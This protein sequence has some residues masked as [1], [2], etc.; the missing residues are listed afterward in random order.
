MLSRWVYIENWADTPL[1]TDTWRCGCTCVCVFFFVCVHVLHMHVYCVTAWGEHLFADHKVNYKHSRSVTPKKRKYLYTKS[2]YR[3]S[4][5]NMYVCPVLKSF[6]HHIRQAQSNRIISLM[7]YPHYPASNHVTQSCN[8]THL[9]YRESSLTNNNTRSV[10]HGAW[11]CAYQRCRGVIWVWG[12]FVVRAYVC[13]CVCVVGGGV[14]NAAK[15]TDT[16]THTH[17]QTHII[18]THFHGQ[19]TRPLHLQPPVHVQ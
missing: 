8:L 7:N 13:V 17:T 18:H 12:D 2:T 15:V 19:Y 11:W 16:L 3:P 6:R 10:Q 14:I 9:I 5:I 1:P 4:S